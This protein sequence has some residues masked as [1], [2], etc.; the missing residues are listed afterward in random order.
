MRFLNAN[1]LKRYTLFS[2]PFDTVSNIVYIT[3]H[4]YHSLQVNKL[5][6]ASGLLLPQIWK[7]KYYSE[8]LEFKMSYLHRTK[9]YIL[10]NS[11]YKYEK[12]CR[13]GY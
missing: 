1:E 13:V 9:Y 3:F 2:T 11:G 6:C 5:E 12:L 7:E 4:K 10:V 8:V